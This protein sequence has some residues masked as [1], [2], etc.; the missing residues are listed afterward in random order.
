MNLPITRDG[1]PART[2]NTGSG[3]SGTIMD[4]IMGCGG[5]VALLFGKTSSYDQDAFDKLPNSLQEKLIAEAMVLLEVQNAA[6]ST[7]ALFSYMISTLNHVPF[8]IMGLVSS[9]LFIASSAILLGAV[10]VMTSALAIPTDHSPNNNTIIIIGQGPPTSAP[11]TFALFDDIS[12]SSG[13]KERRRCPGL[14]SV[15]F[16]GYHAA[17]TEHNSNTSQLLLLA[18]HDLPGDLDLILANDFVL[19][20]NDE[21]GSLQVRNNERTNERTNERAQNKHQQSF[22]RSGLCL[23]CN[24]PSCSTL[25]PSGRHDSF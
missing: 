11:T 13:W 23:R 20:T 19:P 18:I 12:S 7:Y 25:R 1:G 5:V 10:I 16:A 14:G 4:M 22:S 2:T 9:P 6:Q 8:T 21:I 17:T 15:L 3:R 24:P